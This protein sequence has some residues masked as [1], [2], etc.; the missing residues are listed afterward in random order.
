MA[1]SVVAVE[2]EKDLH[3]GLATLLYIKITVP[4]IAR[5]KYRVVRISIDLSSGT[6]QFNVRSLE[7]VHDAITQRV[8]FADYNDVHCKSV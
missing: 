4:I 5:Q 3:N 8:V 2:A 1:V 6:T 7:E